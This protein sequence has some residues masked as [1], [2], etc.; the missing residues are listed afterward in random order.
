MVVVCVGG[1]EGCVVS[2][3]VCVCRATGGTPGGI[4]AAR[5]GVCV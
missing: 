5:V 1:G 2:V 4:D 3:C